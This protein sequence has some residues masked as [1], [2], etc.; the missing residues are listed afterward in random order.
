MNATEQD[1]DETTPPS[2]APSLQRVWDELARR[3]RHG[4]YASINVASITR[5]NAIIAV[6]AL[7]RAN[8]PRQPRS[9]VSLRA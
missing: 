9:S 7:L 5:R 2:L 8:D 4:G 3:C 1:R 6:D